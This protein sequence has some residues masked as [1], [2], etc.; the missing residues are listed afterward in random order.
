MENP[1]NPV[2]IHHSGADKK[3][4]LVIENDTSIAD[5]MK[6]LLADEDYNYVIYD[7]AVEIQPLIQEHQPD[8]ILLD[9]LLDNT[10]GGELCSQV[11]KVPETAHIPVI[12]YSAAPKVLQSLGYYG[13]DLFVAKPFDLEYL[14]EQIKGL[15]QS[16]EALA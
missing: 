1:K 11:K 16:S 13:C 2:A 12:I 5:V 14:A 9:Y 3:K 6:E 15:L 8:L 10:N 7:D 4:I